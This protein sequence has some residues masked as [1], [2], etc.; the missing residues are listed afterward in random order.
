[1][2]TIL[3]ILAAINLGSCSAADQ[4]TTVQDPLLDHLVGTWVLRGTIAGKETTHDIVA[5]WVP[6]QAPPRFALGNP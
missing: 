6:G 2:R 1:M 4:P 3:M 5:Q